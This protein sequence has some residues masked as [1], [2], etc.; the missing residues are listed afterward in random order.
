MDYISKHR[1][2]PEN[3]N[4]L[5]ENEVFVFGTNLMGHYFGDAARIANEQ[6]G[7]G[8]VSEGINGQAYAIP[9]VLAGTDRIKQYIDTFL[10]YAL[11]HQDK[12]FLVTRIGCGLAGFSDDEIAPMFAEALAI[13]NITLPLSFWSVLIRKGLYFPHIPQHRIAPDMIDSLASNEI[14]VFGSNL[15]GKHY[16]GAAHVANTRFGAKWGVGV[17]IAGNTYAI[18]TMRAGVDMIKPYIDDFLQFAR[19]HCEFRFLVT[20]IGCGIA[21]FSDKEIAP[22]FAQAVHIENIALPLSFWKVIVAQE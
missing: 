5:A 15:A 19:E 1:I 3:I 4:S 16:G 8:G 10:Q 11:S 14:F 20:R 6:F 9:V 21:G 2:T 12:R 13:E 7:A 22:L 17:G 18:P